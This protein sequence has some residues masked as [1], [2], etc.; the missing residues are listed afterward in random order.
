[1]ITPKMTQIPQGPIHNK[2]RSGSGIRQFSDSDSEVGEW[3][4]SKLKTVNFA[5]QVKRVVNNA[6]TFDEMLVHRA[7]RSR[8]SAPEGDSYQ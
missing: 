1:M 6:K 4:Q 5:N 3:K 7:P 8:S 2:S